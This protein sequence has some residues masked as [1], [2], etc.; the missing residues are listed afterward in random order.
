MIFSVITICRNDLSGLKGTHASISQQNFTDFEWLVMDGA[1]N[2]GTL[3]YLKAI[4]E[5]RLHFIS[6][7]DR[8]LYDA[9]NKGIALAKGE[10][11]VFL[12]S[13]DMFASANTLEHVHEA[14]NQ[15]PKKP[16]L[17]Y[18][19]AVD[20]EPNGDTHYRKA[21]P[22]KTIAKGMFT[23]HQSIFFARLP[24]G[25]QPLYQ[26]DYKLSAD[27]Q[28]IIHYLKLEKEGYSILKLDEPLC[29]FELGGL[30]ESQRYQAIREDFQIRKTNLRLNPLTNHFLFAAHSVHTFL[31]R[32]IPNLM[33]RVRYSR[34]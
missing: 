7:N 10:F 24:D 22:Y 1:S 4:D 31:K 16:A 6:E 20:F 19:D 17:V 28:F 11:M 33:K 14:V 30:N 32:R 27:Y 29:R 5:P 12:N 9:M 26:L 23:Q 8:G 2:D 13:G 18:G 34:H 25:Q 21:R 15:A 3:E